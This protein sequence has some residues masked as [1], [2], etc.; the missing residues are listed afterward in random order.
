MVKNAGKRERHQGRRRV[1]VTF[2][3]IP[4]YASGGPGLTIDGVRPGGP[5]DAAG[6]QA[7]DIIIEIDGK[8]VQDIYDYMHRLEELK[9]GQEVAVIVKRGEDVLKLIVS[10]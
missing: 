10:P 5:A 9:K 2:G 7:G 6:V 1:K 4:S 8:D 3:I